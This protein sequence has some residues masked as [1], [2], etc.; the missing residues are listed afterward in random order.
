M[1]RRPAGK[2]EAGR[3]GER[4]ARAF[5]TT[6]PQLHPAP[7][8]AFLQLH[9]PL[10]GLVTL[11]RG[12]ET[13]TPRHIWFSWLNAHSCGSGLSFPEQLRPAFHL[14]PLQGREAGL[15][16]TGNMLS[17]M[18]TVRWKHDYP[19][20]QENGNQ[21]WWSWDSAKTLVSSPPTPN[22]GQSQLSF[23]NPSLS[24]RKTSCVTG[25]GFGRTFM[26][27]FCT[28][29]KLCVSGSSGCKAG[30]REE[31]KGIS[32]ASLEMKWLGVC[33]HCRGHGLDAWLRN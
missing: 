32:G 12:G 10:L 24:L 1:I 14:L 16:S 31:L 33:F 2:E 17:I 6:E 26:E 27:V 20:V 25:L 23:W 13:Q 5:P 30:N 28:W 3:R 21:L 19:L 9:P 22:I 11:W 4:Q 15:F 29:N 7:R 18:F 8:R